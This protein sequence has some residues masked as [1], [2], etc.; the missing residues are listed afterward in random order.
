MLRLRRCRPGYR[1][2]SVLMTGL[3]CNANAIDQLFPWCVNF[4]VCRVN[5][6]TSSRLQN[7]ERTILLVLQRHLKALACCFPVYV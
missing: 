1:R 2:I 6:V 3:C 7:N 5:V 4:K